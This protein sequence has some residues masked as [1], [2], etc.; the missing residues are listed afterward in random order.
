[1]GRGPKMMGRGPKMR[2]R[3]GSRRRGTRSGGADVRV[4]L[5]PTEGSGTRKPP[6]QPV[7]QTPH[8]D[9]ASE[10]RNKTS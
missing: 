5:G 4:S 2:R 8:P 1:M 6:P 7:L 3:G 10:T 9:Q